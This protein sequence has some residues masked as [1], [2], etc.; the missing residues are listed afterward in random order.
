[1]TFN[2]IS[3]AFEGHELFADCSRQSL[4]RLFPFVKIVPFPRGEVLV[5]PG[6]PAREFMVILDGEVRQT[7]GEEPPAVHFQHY[8]GEE[9][10]IGLDL[11]VTR[12]MAVR[13]T[14]VMVIPKKEIEGLL[15]AN[16]AIRKRLSASFS[17]RFDDAVERHAPGTPD[18]PEVFPALPTADLRRTIGWL[19]AL[20]VPVALFFGLQRGGELTDVPALHFVSLAGIVV[21]MWIFRLIPDF[22]TALFGIMGVI[23]LGLAPPSVALSGFS[24]N[25]FFLALGIFGLS[26]VISVSGL[27]FRILLWLLRLG[28]SHK[29]WYN[30]SLFLLGLL[31]TPVIPTTN[32]R[33]AIVGTFFDNLTSLFGSG[34]HPVERARLSASVLGGVS[35]LS[36]VFLSSKSINFVVFGLLPFQEQFQFQW[37]NWFLAAA[38]CG[39]VL[40]MLYL[41]GLWLFFINPAKPSISREVVKRQLTILGPMNGA[42]WAGTAGL[43][44]LLLSFFTAPFH[45]IPLPWIALCILVILLMFDFLGKKDF[46]RQI[47]WSFL[48]FLGSLIGF[49]AAMKHVGV[50]QWITGRLDWLA[51]V[52]ESNFHAFIILL[53]ITLFL[54]RLALPINATV[55]LFA[56]LL[57]PIAENVGVNPWL[58]GFLILLFSESYIWPYQA[59]YY[60]L[61]TAMTGERQPGQ[62]DRTALFFTVVALLKVAAIFLSIPY[63]HDLGLL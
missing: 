27:S 9:A 38:V 15:D 7:D 34:L 26:V 40:L 20:T 5:R 48:V 32:G 16:P 8:L 49:I 63:W 53:A 43:V 56:A 3:A 4:S 10:A 25:S 31:L 61:F 52:M 30:A 42:E 17:R 51:Y 11:Y 41:L 23:L 14:T 54:T 62:S 50:D 36:A 45:Q 59:S 2:A 60:A 18:A 6:Q 12:A 28:P 19:A 29:S 44:T 21:V 57:I 39:A 1:M 22:A 33:V 47:D 58:V 13:D 55:V 46:R 24:S 35:L 37:L